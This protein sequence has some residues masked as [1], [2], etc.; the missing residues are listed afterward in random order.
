MI[1]NPATLK[2]IAL[3]ACFGVAGFF[4]SFSAWSASDAP[5]YIVQ[6]VKAD[7]TASS[8]S[9]AREKAVTEARKKAYDIVLNRIIIDDEKPKV[10]EPQASELM[11]FVSEM[12][13]M[14]E[15]TSS[16]R[17]MADLDF[18]FNDSEIKKYLEKNST[19]Y[20]NTIS[21]PVLLLPI[22]TDGK[23]IVFADGDNPWLQYLA[24]LKMP[25]SVLPLII[26]IGDE[27]DADHTS[28]LLSGRYDAESIDNLK[29]R[30]KTDRIVVAE[31]QEY[32]SAKG[33]S[34]SLYDLTEE[35]LGNDSLNFTVSGE[36]SS[37]EKIKA[38]AFNTIRKKLEQ[39][40]KKDNVVYFSEASAITVLIPFKDI[41][42]WVSIKNTMD[43]MPIIE[44]Y[45]LKAVKKDRLQVSIVFGR[46]IDRLMELMDT[47]G[48]LLKAADK[49]TW[50]LYKK[51]PNN[52][53]K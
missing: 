47:N 4:V 35:G 52:H 42:E 53:K 19:G 26:P 17:Y 8:S 37:P 10:S 32:E 13:V 27:E 33:V 40:W 39:E 14:N 28:A 2:R 20:T 30:Y 34:F 49:N 3:G 15:K 21:K 44:H 7:A 24:G 5:L 46:N 38:A 29:K 18:H 6:G 11:N 9:A 31:M 36:K 1:K 22:Y 23:S 43:K 45:E 12:S 16:V 41:S 48:L 50:V 51:N 25:V